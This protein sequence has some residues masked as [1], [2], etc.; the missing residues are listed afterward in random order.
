MIILTRIETLELVKMSFKSF[1]II[2]HSQTRNA[3][4]TVRH[5]EIWGSRNISAGIAMGY[6]LGDPG[7]ITGGAEHFFSLQRPYWL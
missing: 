2:I 7:S 1:K 4:I 3:T 6:G 5:G